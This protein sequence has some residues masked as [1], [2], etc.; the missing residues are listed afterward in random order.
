MKK[1]LITAMMLATLASSAALSSAAGTAYSPAQS[2][3]YERYVGKYPSDL[4]KGEPALKTR[5]L[6]LLGRNYGLF[7]SH[8]GVEMPIENDQGGLVVRGC[9]PHSCTTEDGILVIDLG[10]GKLHVAI[11]SQKFG[12]RFRTF[13]EDRAHIPAALKRAMSQP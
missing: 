4:F 9:L 6:A 12:G 13:S 10:T 8:L 11:L 3:N 7:M 2:G 5:L 1:M